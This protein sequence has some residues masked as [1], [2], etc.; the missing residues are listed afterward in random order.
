[1]SQ[2]VLTW[3]RVIDACATVEGGRWEC[4]TVYHV[5]RR[6]AGRGWE[7][8]ELNA[9]VELHSTQIGEDLG[10]SLL[11]FIHRRWVLLVVMGEEALDPVDVGLF[12]A[13]GAVSEA[14]C[15]VHLVQ[16]FPVPQP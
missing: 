12:R 13:D 1:M 15:V 3:M 16:N 5:M 6:T 8:E 9:R 11:I 2:A 4:A 10:D 7:G 14:D